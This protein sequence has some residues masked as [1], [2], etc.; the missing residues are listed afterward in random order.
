ML[1]KS[2]QKDREEKQITVAGA[3]TGCAVSQNRKYELVE[4]ADSFC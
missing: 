1:H 4:T 3:T 2:K